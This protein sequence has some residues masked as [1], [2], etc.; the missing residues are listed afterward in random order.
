MGGRRLDKALQVGCQH[1]PAHFGGHPFRLQ[2]GVHRQA[3][4]CGEQPLRFR[5]QE[6]VTVVVQFPGRPKFHD[7]PPH[8]GGYGP[9]AAVSL[10]GQEG[11]DPC[12]VLERH[13]DTRVHGTFLVEGQELAQQC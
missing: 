2:Q 7:E 9:V 6:L 8:N 10:G 12:R 1:V 4:Q 3:V 13:P 11:P 5:D